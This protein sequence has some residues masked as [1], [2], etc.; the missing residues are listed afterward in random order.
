MADIY[1]QKQDLETDLLFDIVVENND[2][3]LDNTYATA[4]LLSIFTDASERQ[5][6]T[7]IDGST[8]GN[9]NYNVDKLSTENIKA[10]KDGTLAALQWLISDGIVKTITVETEKIRNRLNVRI[11][12]DTDAENELNLIYSLDESM[13]ILDAI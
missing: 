2:I 8:V 3:K 9:K 12:F 13:E 5:I 11:E 1:L 4:A 6:G 7:Q 10:Y